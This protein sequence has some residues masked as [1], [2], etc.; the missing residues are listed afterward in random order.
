M[1]EYRCSACNDEFEIQRKFSDPPLEVCPKCGK[2]PVDKM[3]S[4]NSF[5][6]KGSGWY[7]T[8]YASGGSGSGGKAKAPSCPGSK[9]SC[10]G[11]PGSTD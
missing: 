11:C 8:D 1:Y 6:L 3:I 9:G 2:G 7:R 4:R 10:S 5:A